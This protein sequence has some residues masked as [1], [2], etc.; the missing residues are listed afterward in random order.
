[1]VKKKAFIH[2]RVKEETKKKAEKILARLGLT[3]SEAVNMFY[4]GICN[5]N[6]IPFEVK[7][8]NKETVQ[9]LKD[10][11]EGKNLHKSKNKKEFLKELYS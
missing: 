6:G 10:S 9:A 5:H 3:Q 2:V 11:R 7:I 8:P 4:S 1:M